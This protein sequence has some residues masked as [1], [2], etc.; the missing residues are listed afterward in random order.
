MILQAA[1]ASSFIILILGVIFTFLGIPLTSIL[2][3]RGIIRLG[4]EK[5][6]SVAEKILLALVC[7]IMGVLTMAVIFTGMVFL[8][9]YMIDSGSN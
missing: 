6:A 2:Y 9:D 7:M 5:Q 8:L 3:Y 1:M 4:S